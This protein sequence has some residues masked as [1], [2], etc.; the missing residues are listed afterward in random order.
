M[1][2]LTLAVPRTATL[3]RKVTVP[4][5]IRLVPEPF[6]TVAVRVTLPLRLSDEP[7]ATTT[8]VLA[9]LPTTTCTGLD[10]LAA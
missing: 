6:D 1:P 7:E 10:V 4:P 2:L 5:G 3:L 9:S 8:V